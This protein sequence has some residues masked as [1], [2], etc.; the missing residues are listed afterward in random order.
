[1]FSEEIKAHAA[2]A[3]MLAYSAAHDHSP[4]R[5]RDGMCEVGISD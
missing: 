4:N 1:M 3:W 5:S 2:R